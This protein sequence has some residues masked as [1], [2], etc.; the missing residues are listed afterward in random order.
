MKKENNRNES[1]ERKTKKTSEFLY[2][3][4]NETKSDFYSN[5]LMFVF[6]YKKAY[7]MLTNL[8]ILFLVF[9]VLCYRNLKMYFLEKFLVD[10]HR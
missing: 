6:L 8:I 10:C 1:V 9:L 4:K 3:K 5:L 2:K 7:L